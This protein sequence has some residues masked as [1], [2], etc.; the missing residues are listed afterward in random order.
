MLRHDKVGG[1]FISNGTLAHS[2]ERHYLIVRILIEIELFEKH[3]I[4]DCVADVIFS[5]NIK[6]RP[7]FKASDFNF[8]TGTEE[9]EDVDG[10]LSSLQKS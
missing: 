10:L 8:F 1:V 5:K 7:T 3:R 6:F 4:N 2:Q 9:D